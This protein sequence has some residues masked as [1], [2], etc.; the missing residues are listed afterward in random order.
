M[1][2]RSEYFSRRTRPGANRLRI[3][4]HEAGAWPGA[5]SYVAI[6]VVFAL[7]LFVR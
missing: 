4:A 1:N 7:V 2:Y 5:W 3:E 6:A